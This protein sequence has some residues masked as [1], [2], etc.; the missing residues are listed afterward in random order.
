MYLTAYLF[1]QM[2]LTSGHPEEGGVVPV[3]VHA[4]T[5]R[6]AGLGGVRAEEHVDG[7]FRAAQMN[8]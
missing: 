2:W 1:Q 8:L 7:A 4:I 5:K 3:D 6:T